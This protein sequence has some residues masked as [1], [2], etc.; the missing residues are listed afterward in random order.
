MPGNCVQPKMCHIVAQ[1]AMF[2][3]APERANSPL[4]V[5]QMQFPSFSRRFLA[6]SAIH[7][8]FEKFFFKTLVSRRL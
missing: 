6:R 2:V 3:A 1:L 4:F 8:V 5:A 7:K